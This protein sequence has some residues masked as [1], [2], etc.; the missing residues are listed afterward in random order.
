MPPTAWTN[1]ASTPSTPPSPNTPLPEAQQSPPAMALSSDDGS[2][3][4]KS[5]G[6]TDKKRSPRVK[7]SHHGG[8]SGTSTGP[9]NSTVEVTSMYAS[10]KA[11]C[12]ETGLKATVPHWQS[13]RAENSLKLMDLAGVEA[14][15]TDLYIGNLPEIDLDVNST[16]TTETIQKPVLS[17]EAY[18]KRAWKSYVDGPR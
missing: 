16:E 13:L 9:C 2:S 12:S 10:A 3:G 4:G 11:R 17:S 1:T 6:L 8:S 5:H 7:R 14:N 15:L 18:Y